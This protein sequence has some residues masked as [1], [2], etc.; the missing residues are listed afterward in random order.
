MVRSWVLGMTGVRDGIGQPL[1]A[2]NGGKE[3]DLRSGEV[4]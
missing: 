2:M 1:S 3:Y 4:S